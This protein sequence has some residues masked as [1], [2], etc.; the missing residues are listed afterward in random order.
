MSMPV[1]RFRLSGWMHM[2]GT[3]GGIPA[4]IFFFFF[5][6]GGGGGKKHAQGRPRQRQSR[7]NPLDLPS[8][9]HFESISIADYTTK[10]VHRKKWSSGRDC[11]P[12]VLLVIPNPNVP[13][14]GTSGVQIPAERDIH[15]CVAIYFVFCCLLPT[16]KAPQDE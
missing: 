15:T 13:V 10:A 4:R 7:L 9:R 11:T 5:G 6:G 1:E 16:R 14:D 2:L 3:V 12:V 8:R